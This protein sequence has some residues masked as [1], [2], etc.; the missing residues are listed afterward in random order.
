MKSGE[1]ND[2]KMKKTRH[3]KQQQEGGKDRLMQITVE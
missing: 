1:K 3:F 2:K